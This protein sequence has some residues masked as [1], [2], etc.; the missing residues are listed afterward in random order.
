MKKALS[1]LLCVGLLILAGCAETIVKTVVV[2]EIVPETYLDCADHPQKPVDL[3]DDVLAA[4]YWSEVDAA[5]WDCKDG[6]GDIRTWNN[7]QQPIQ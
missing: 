1:V 3:N 6:Y 5:Y 7:G 2:R 4:I